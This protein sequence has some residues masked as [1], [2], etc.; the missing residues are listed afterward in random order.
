MEIG[1]IRWAGHYN[2]QTGDFNNYGFITRFENNN[3]LY[4]RKESIRTG[5]RLLTR[6]NSSDNELV[7]FD[8][9]PSS[10]KT[11]QFQ[12]ENV[13]F[14]EEVKPED[15]KN[16][17]SAKSLASQKVQ[18]I[19]LEIC[20][21][22]LLGDDP[23]AYFPFLHDTKVR[24]I[25]KNRYKSEC[26]KQQVVSALTDY[27]KQTK[28]P[29]WDIHDWMLIDWK[30]EPLDEIRNLCKAAI[31][32]DIN[33]TPLF[34]DKPSIWRGDQEFFKTL[35]VKTIQ[36]LFSDEKFTLGREDF[37]YIFSNTESN[38]IRELV[39]NIVPTVWVVAQPETIS[40]LKKEKQADLLNQINWESVDLQYI[41]EIAPFLQ[42]IQIN[43]DEKTIQSIASSVEKAWIVED[44]PWW[45]LLSENIKAV[46]LR[47]YRTAGLITELNA[48]VN[49][50]LDRFLAEYYQGE[51]RREFSVQQ[52][53][54]IQAVNGVTL[55]FAVPGSGKTT[56]I[57][58]RAGFMVHAKHISPSAHLVM[59]FNKAAAEEMKARYQKIFPD[60]GDNIPDFRTIHSFCFSVIG[61]LRKKGESFPLL[62]KDSEDEKDEKAKQK[63][64][65]EIADA[66]IHVIGNNNIDPDRLIKYINDIRKKRISEESAKGITLCHDV[67]LEDAWIAWKKKDITQKAILREVMH[68]DA[69]DEDANMLID[70]I[71]TL[72]GFIKNRMLSQEEIDKIT[73]KV[74]KQEYPVKPIYNEY[75]QY[76]QR[77]NLMDFDDM[78]YRAYSGLKK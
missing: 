73:Y 48:T 78:L 51:Q 58:A 11:S 17:L 1:R 2:S 55:L 24:K 21:E 14:L 50:Q 39:C 40:Y 33:V 41:N 76:L 52:K 5:S 54:A 27:F 25:F 36:S 63:R 29:V 16:N 42:N 71:C 47:D 32:A 19:L 37:D 3:D 57:D 30:E 31:G 28:A 69:F 59:T 15:L 13:C 62:L 34:L 7:V 60:D 66:I 22:A 53:E 26:F 35:P 45:S 67:S 68:K 8:V 46:V 72:I 77:E 23:K 43:A 10:R 56:V 65:L 44:S 38:N 18:R 9:I 70:T 74:E 20:P 12:A 4:F 75:Q 6:F 61:S 49:P 64:D